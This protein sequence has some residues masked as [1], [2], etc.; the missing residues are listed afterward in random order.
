MNSFF[1]QLV[2]ASFAHLLL[3]FYCLAAV[4]DRLDI[5]GT[6]ISLIPP[7][8]FSA[9]S[10]F[11]GVQNEELQA[12][13]MVIQLPGSV[14]EVTGS[15]TPEQLARQ[16][17]VLLSEKKIHIGTND[18]VLYHFRQ[19][20]V[21]EPFLKW[22]LALSG[23]SESALVTAAFPESAK[24]KLSDALYEAVLS[25]RWNSKTNSNDLVGLGFTVKS[26]PSLKLA[27]RISNALAF[28]RDGKLP[29]RPHN[30][31]LY[32]VSESDSK[33]TVPN[34]EAFARR[35]IL[36]TATVTN[37]NISRSVKVQIDG[38]EGYELVAT[39]RKLNPAEPVTV[40][41]VLLFQRE[42]FFI[43][44]GLT[45]PAGADDCLKA[46]RESTRSFKRNESEP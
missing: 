35:H 15:F 24:K 27:K 41:L 36:Q 46:F 2:V 13:I 25:A 30:D 10:R 38:L 12:S 22:V 5:I 23:E 19:S 1:K 37:I 28:T 39:A 33:L 40:Y 18:A 29:G 16:K 8:G 31:P 6:Q 4:K 32:I 26:H 43:F 9:A 3:Q 17:V 34:K 11:T 21:S 20:S 14:G 44:Q 7:D 45:P 42:G